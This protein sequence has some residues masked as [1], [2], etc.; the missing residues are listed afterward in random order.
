[1]LE[2]G[3]YDQD[4]V[5][6]DDQLFTVRFDI[7]KLP[8]GERTL[9]CF[10]SDPKVSC[11]ETGRPGKEGLGFLSKLQHVMYICFL[12][13]ALNF[14]LINLR[15]LHYGFLHYTDQFGLSM[16]ATGGWIGKS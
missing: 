7:A 4:R 9:M 5:T 15:S 13:S 10:K 11:E 14:T 3:V 8:L 6:Q 2:L 16:L 12:P 1:M